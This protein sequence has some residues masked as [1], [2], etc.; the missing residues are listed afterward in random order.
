MPSMHNV[1]AR[2]IAKKYGANTIG[3]KD[4]ISRPLAKRLKSRRPTPSGT[5]S[6]SFKGFAKRSTSLART[7]RPPRR[8]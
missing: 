5:V 3:A 7:K 2:R 8:R 4:R 6:V 1:T